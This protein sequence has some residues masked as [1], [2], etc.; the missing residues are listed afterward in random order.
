MS[1][2]AFTK[3]LEMTETEVLSERRKVLGDHYSGLLSKGIE[4][5]FEMVTHD[6]IIVRERQRKLRPEHVQAIRQSL[7]DLGGT[8]LLQP[9]LLTGDYI[10]IDGAHRCEATRLEG[11]E[12]VPA[13]V[14]V[15]ATEADRQLIEAE[16]NLVRLQLSPVEIAQVWT[17]NKKA[18]Q[19]RTLENAEI[20]RSRGGAASVKN[21]K[22]SENTSSTGFIADSNKAGDIHQPL[23]MRELALQVTGMAL[24]TIE[25]VIEVQNLAESD[26]ASPALRGAAERAVVKL[27]KPGTSVEAVHK[28]L[29]AMKDQETDAANPIE[30][31]KRKLERLT[32]KALT[33]VTLLTEH[34]E[35]SLGEELKQAVRVDRLNLE[36]VETMRVATTRSL[37]MLLAIECEAHDSDTPVAL[38]YLGKI[39]T[40]SLSRHTMKHLGLEPKERS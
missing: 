22:G 30:A 34:L 12:L 11:W 4:V 40:E 25:K 16:A 18:F 5:R 39:V 35:G 37:A 38:E 6:K 32:D 19:A 1:A 8:I 33:D 21:L 7:R 10:L 3:P 14:L 29:K 15:G 28:Q 24:P 2:E 23:S 27:S 17:S 36:A 9:I 26:T 31:R 20:G 13:L